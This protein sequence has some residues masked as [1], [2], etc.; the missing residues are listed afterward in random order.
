M[1]SFAEVM[2]IIAKVIEYS[3]KVCDRNAQSCNKEDLTIY[4]SLV[5]I[6]P[7]AIVLLLKYREYRKNAKSRA[8]TERIKSELNARQHRE[9]AKY[10]GV[11]TEVDNFAASDVTSK[12]ACNIKREGD[13]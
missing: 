10:F 3:L 4:I 12:A 7:T 5:F 11:E 9:I 13:D 1:S 2:G 6:M 8:E